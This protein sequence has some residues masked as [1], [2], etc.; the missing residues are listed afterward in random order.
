[1]KQNGGVWAANASANIIKYFQDFTEIEYA[2]PKLDSVAIPQFSAGA[3]ENWGL[4]T[5]R[6]GHH[7]G[8][9]SIRFNSIMKM[10]NFQGGIP[11]AHSQ[12]EYRNR[13]EED[14]S[15]FGA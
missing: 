9:I 1:M 2:M 3:M 12:R 7:H 6:Y 5:Y 8:I 14:Y 11:F 15:S 13:E 4:N 10:V